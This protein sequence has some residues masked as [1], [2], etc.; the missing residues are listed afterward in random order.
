MSVATVKA[1]VNPKLFVSYSWTNPDHESWVVRLATDLRESGVDTVLDKWDLKEGHDAHAFM[2][3]MVT[4]PEIKKVI[5][6]CD[7]LYAEKT[8]GRAGGVGKEAQIISSEIYEKQ[9]QSK[10]VAV[11]KERDP[12]GKPYLP[13]YYRSRIYI[14]LSDPGSYSENFE[15][16]LRWIYD[17][18][19]YKKPDLGAKPVFLVNEALGGASLST[20]SR[21]RRA[22]DAL[23]NGREYALPATAEYLSLLCSEIGKLRL[24]VK[25]EP[26]DEAVVQSIESFLPYRNEA[27][28]LF[29]NLVTHTDKPESWTM[30]HRFFESLMAYLDP[31]EGVGDYREWDWDNFRFIV[32]E[33]FLYAV[34]V[35]IRYERFESASHLM[36]TQYYVPSGARLGRDSMVPFATLRQHMKSLE[37]RNNRLQLGRLSI[38]ADLLKERC[39]QVGIDFR[40]LMQADFVLFLRSALETVGFGRRWFP[41][42]L[43]YHNQGPFEVFARSRSKSYFERAKILLGMDDKQSLK[44]LLDSLNTNP[45]YMPRWEFE[46][47][48]PAYLLGFD[49]LAT[50]A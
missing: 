36:S 35:M 49:E 47:F 33:L 17:Q 19:L 20:S 48:N 12:N 40:H 25:A 15:Q 11:L 32:H 50:K 37:Y 44:A 7:K 1:G 31:P 26:F 5:L 28:E 16:L 10:F 8:D 38:R 42:T 18:P 39:K 34:A 22:L 41:E 21:L 6:I 46:S 9:D 27:V 45:A 43:L 14:D 29:V 3:R 13:V 23:R 2:E 4:D 30:V 24:D